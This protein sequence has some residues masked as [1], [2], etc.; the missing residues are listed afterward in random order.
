MMM[1]RRRGVSVS[2][3]LRRAKCYATGTH[4]KHDRSLLQVRVLE[5]QERKPRP[6]WRRVN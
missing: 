1:R 2:V 3:S 5:A 4:E 6:E